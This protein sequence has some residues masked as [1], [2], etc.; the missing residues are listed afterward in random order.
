MSV[1]QRTSFPES[2]TVVL[3]L[4]SSG[5]VALHLRIPAWA[6]GASMSVNGE[7]VTVAPEAGYVVID[8][9]WAPG[10]EVVLELPIAVRTLIGHPFVEEIANHGCVL[11]GPVVYCAE[12]ADQPLD[13]LLLPCRRPVRRVDRRRTVGGGPSR[14]PG[15]R[16]PA[17]A[18]TGDGSAVRR[19]A[20]HPGDTRPATARPVRRLGQPR[21]R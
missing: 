7:P 8:R 16:R 15:H 2:G 9:T 21:T 5:D 1:E 10:D 12:S 19:A 11:R 18:D 17:R 3:A 13:G 14:R 20:V 4:A 6:H